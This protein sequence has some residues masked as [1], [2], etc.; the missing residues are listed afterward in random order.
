MHF[1]RQFEYWRMDRATM[2]FG[3]LSRIQCTDLP[4]MSFLLKSEWNLLS[5]C[6]KS[7]LKYSR[8]DVMGVED[9]DEI[10]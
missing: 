9:K 1:S 3:L 8:A 2:M 6:P 7:D 10:T 5:N 4:L